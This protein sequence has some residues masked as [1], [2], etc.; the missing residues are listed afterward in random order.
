MGCILLSDDGIYTPEPKPPYAT[1]DWIL[2]RLRAIQRHAEGVL[3]MVRGAEPQLD[4]RESFNDQHY[5]EVAAVREVSRRNGDYRGESFDAA[6][7]A[8]V[9]AAR[10][11]RDRRAE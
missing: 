11:E 6:Q 10:A 9:V 8:R 2:A 5:G 3:E 7:Y 4:V 1:H